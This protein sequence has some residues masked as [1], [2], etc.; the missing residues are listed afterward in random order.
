MIVGSGGVGKFQ[1]ERLKKLTFTGAFSKEFTT[2]YN[3][4]KSEDVVP[5]TR[6]LG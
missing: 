6:N 4:N 1:D 2:A 5:L 3:I